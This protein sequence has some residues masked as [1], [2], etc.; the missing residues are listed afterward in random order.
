MSMEA[1]EG[2]WVPECVRA[3]LRAAGYSTRALEDME[4]H[5]REW[6]R[7]MRAFG[8]VLRLPGVFSQI[9][10]DCWDCGGNLGPNTS[11]AA[12]PKSL[13]YCMGY[14]QSRPPFI[15]TSLCHLRQASS[16]SM[17]SSIVTPAQPQPWKSSISS[18]PKKPSHL[19]LPGLHPLPGI[20]LARPLPSDH[21][22]YAF[23]ELVAELGSAFPAADAGL[24]M[25]AVAR[26][27]SVQTWIQ[28][29]AAY[30]RSWLDEI[31]DDPSALARAASEA[32]R[33]SDL[34]IGRYVVTRAEQARSRSRDERPL[35]E[36]AGSAR[37]GAARIAAEG[38]TPEDMRTK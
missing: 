33:A 26:G 23:E 14:L 28:N 15:L 16:M 38:I 32:S 4:P 29:H 8:G 11:Y 25:S 6:D 7:W 31:R 27:G 20:D 3:Y 10:V 1:T 37:E 13:G 5:V 9:K 22:S 35:S 24:D 2:Y 36:R 21:E 30:L 19:A 12:R 17:N 18:L 34:V